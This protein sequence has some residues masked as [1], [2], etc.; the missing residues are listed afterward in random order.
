[1]MKRFFHGIITLLLVLIVVP[2]NARADL[3][4]V[5]D[6]T[7]I[8]S[9]TQ[10]FN[11][12]GVGNFDTVE[13]FM[14]SGGPFEAPPFA[15]F[16]IAGWSGSLINNNYAIGSG[17]A[18]TSL[19]WNI[20]FSGSQSSPLGFDFL[21]WEGGVFGTLKEAAKATWSGSG[22][23]FALFTTDG[24]I[25]SNSVAY[26]R[27]PPPVPEPATMLLLGSGLLGLVGFGRRFK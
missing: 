2:M 8:G 15:G 4:R 6:P 9:W 10:A 25:G 5:G 11:E 14:L 19:T 16:S 21:A 23:S 7:E 26:D 1:M 12:S 22:W 20:N 17:P 18:T 13:T 3:M 24:T 27:C